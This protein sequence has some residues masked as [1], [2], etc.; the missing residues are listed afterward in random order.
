MATKP[1]R[2]SIFSDIPDLARD[3]LKGLRQFIASEFERECGAAVLVESSADPYDLKTLTSTNLG[4]GEEA[5]DVMEVDTILL[6]ELVKAGNLQPLDDSF[7]VTENEYAASAVQSVKYSSHFKNRLYG[8]PTL[9]CA[10]FLM[11]LADAGHTPK[12]PILQRDWTSFEQLKEAVDKAEEGSCHKLFMAG[13]FR[14]SWG[15]PMFYL[16]AYVDAHGG[17]SVYQGLDGPLDDNLIADLKHFTEYGVLPNGKN[18]DTDGTYHKDHDLLI[19]NV[20]DSEHILMY[21]YS[22]NLGEALQ[23]SAEKEKHKRVLN[24]VSPPLDKSNFLLTHTDAAVVNKSRFKDPQR[25]ELIIKFVRFY[26]SLAFRVK[27]AFGEDLPKNVP[28]PRYV[29]PARKD[30]FTQQRAADDACYKEFHLALQHSVAAPNHGVYGK[31]K[32]LQAELEKALGMAP[33]E[34]PQVK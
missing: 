30:F 12:A 25:A 31:R 29:L 9:Q 33:K 14:G 11:E 15:L 4:T 7:T 2:V 28:G 8:V 1:L 20:V 10:N 32:A 26:T 17:G 5:Y 3:E 27:F 18:P 21:A 22:E 34:H 13:D 19:N 6:G 24:I 23:R 16:D